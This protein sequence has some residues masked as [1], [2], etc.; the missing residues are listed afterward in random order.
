MNYGG[1]EVLVAGDENIHMRGGHE[2][3]GVRVGHK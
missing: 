2:I 1:N 3:S